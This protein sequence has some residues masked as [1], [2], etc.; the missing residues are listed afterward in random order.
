[1]QIF[2]NFEVIFFIKNISKLL[3]YYNLYIFMR[4]LNKD[5]IFLE[6]ESTLLVFAN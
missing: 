3:N 4:F 2:K 5:N 6:L 1:M